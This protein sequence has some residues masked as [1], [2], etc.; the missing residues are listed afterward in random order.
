MIRDG[1]KFA[2]PR[3]IRGNRGDLASRWALMR[4]LHSLNIKTLSV[5]CENPDDIP[6]VGFPSYS[7][8]KIRNLLQSGSGKD[9]LREADTILWA[10][11][12]DLQ[13]DSSLT[14][15]IF[16]R[17]LFGVYRRQ[18]KKI[19]C[20]FQG[21]GPIRTK[22]GKLLATSL[23][24]QVDIFIARDPAS[25]R[26]VKSIAPR[27]EVR[28][29]H[30]AIFLPGLEL[31]LKESVPLPVELETVFS[32]SAPVVGINLRQWFHFSSSMLPYEI[33]QHGY[34]HRSETKMAALI[35]QTTQLIGNIRNSYPDAHILLI[36]AY[37]AN[38]VN[39]E[40]DTPWLARV[41]AFFGNDDHIH[42]G[43]QALTIPQYFQAISR[44]D[45]M[46]AMRL[47][48]S[49]IALRFGVPAINISYTL[50]GRDIY[51][52][53]GLMENVLNLD[54]FMQQGPE[55]ITGMIRTILEEPQL[56]RQIVR[57]ATQAAIAQNMT[58]LNSLFRP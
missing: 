9:A 27:L 22:L 31:D 50:K 16:L 24:E 29:A 42:L 10:V 45:L 41:Q 12:L 2:L 6:P 56:K 3:V 19:W 46:V 18:G 35:N 11:G 52:Q 49:L 33:S 21:A 30:D 32:N 34:Q 28:Q 58:V 17:L 44:L 7:Y 4:S 54:Q 14:K 36:S 53:L 1:L 25:F 39:W 13:D 20:V 51:Q 40:D 37:Q 47:H 38:Q 23:L 48:S 43:N 15:L 8:G 5:F 57:A 55:Q 26:L